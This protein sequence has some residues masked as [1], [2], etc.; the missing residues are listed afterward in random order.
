MIFTRSLKKGMVSDGIF[1]IVPVVLV[2]S[3]GCVDYISHS[4]FRQHVDRGQVLLQ[5]G[6]C[7]VVVGVFEFGVSHHSPNLLKGRS[8]SL[9]TFLDPCIDPRIPCDR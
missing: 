3:I 4:R 9:G 1:A 8:L 7:D 6:D 5:Q 2:R